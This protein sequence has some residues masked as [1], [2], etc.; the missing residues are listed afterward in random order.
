MPK[1]VR[2]HEVGGPEVLRVEEEPPKQPDKGE[3]Q[4]KV[5]ALGLNRAESM[6]IR[7][8]YVEPPKF[9]AGVGYESAGVVE[10]VGPDVD[11]NW[12][13]KRVGIK[14]QTNYRPE[15]TFSRGVQ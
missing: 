7:G 11:E 9:P 15:S 3:A 10:A 2:L 5:Q 12:V 14:N 1:M 4:L 8:Q 13:G 6:F